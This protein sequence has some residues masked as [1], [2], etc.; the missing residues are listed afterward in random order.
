MSPE[1]YPVLGRRRE[2]SVRCITRE[3]VTPGPSRAFPI[4]LLISDLRPRRV[5]FFF[6]VP[7]VLSRISTLRDPAS[8][9]TMIRV[10]RASSSWHEGTCHQFD[11]APCAHWPAASINEL[12]LWSVQSRVERRSIIAREPRVFGVGA[13]DRLCIEYQHHKQPRS[14][15]PISAGG[16]GS[17]APCT[18]DCNVITLYKKNRCHYLSWS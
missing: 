1:D 15:A 11:D 4:R 10:R 5:F 18:V 9:R 16:R 2:S 14:P 17:S 8:S 13:L 12:F 3:Q 7:R 6:F